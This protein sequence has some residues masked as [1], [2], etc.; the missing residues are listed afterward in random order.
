MQIS[1]VSAAGKNTPVDQ[2]NMRI[3]NIQ[4]RSHW[5]VNAI[6]L[7]REGNIAVVRDN[8]VV[9]VAGKKLILYDCLEQKSR[10]ISLHNSDI[11]SI[12]YVAISPNQNYLTISVRLQSTGSR[13]KKVEL[14]IYDLESLQKVPKKPI[15][16]D[17]AF[18]SR[19]EDTSIACISYSADSSIF[20]VSSNVVSAGVILYERLNG[21]ILLQIPTKDHVCRVSFN[22][23][24]NSRLCTTGKNNMFQFWRCNQKTIHHIP[25]ENKRSGV[26][27]YL[28]HGNILCF[29]FIEFPFA[30]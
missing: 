12:G 11:A 17:Y 27:N 21:N 9:Y 5:G 10:I 22:P 2:F 7:S 15:V 1:R 30:R 26:H 8:E 4:Y 14:M 18:V 13:D 25:I 29:I 6:S 19:E 16:I 24:D 28:C 3:K 20:A 23:G